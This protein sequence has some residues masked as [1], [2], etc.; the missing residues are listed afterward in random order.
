MMEVWPHFIRPW[1]L[2]AVPLPFLLLWQLTH[3]Q[4]RIGHWQRL[5]PMAFQGVLLTPGQRQRGH[6]PSW[7]LGVGWT[8]GLVALSG[9]AWQHSLP[10]AQQVAD[11]LV[12]VWEL[13][14]ELYATDASPNRLH[15]ARRKLLDLLKARQ[16]AQT[17]LL[18]F[19]GS[20]HILV[21]LSDDLATA[22]NLLSAIKPALMPEPGHRAD[23]GIAQAL[24]L[25]EQTGLGRGRLLLMGTHLDSRERNAIRQQLLK[26]P[27][28][29]LILG[30]GTPQGAPVLQEDGH[31]LQD[32]QGQ[33]VI[34]RQDQAGLMRFA[35]ERGGLYQQATLDDSDLAALGLLHPR[36]APNLQMNPRTQ[37]AWQDQGH[38]LLL[39]LLLLA[40]GAARKGWLFCFALL[41]VFPPSSYAF[42]WQDL[43]L[44][45][46]QQ[47]F[48]WLEQQQPHAAAQRFQ[49]SQ[50]QGIAYYQAENYTA[51]AAC[52]AQSDTAIAHYN[53]GNALAMNQQPDA[54]LEAY[55]RAL[56]L[57]PDLAAARQNKALL[58][59]WLA[60]RRAEQASAATQAAESKALDD[61]SIQ[62]NTQQQA[63]PANAPS[64]ALANATS[65]SPSDQASPAEAAHLAKHDA[66][67][68]EFSPERRAQAAT[69]EHQ[70][71]LEQ[72]LRRIPDDPGELLRRK[73]LYEQH[74]RQTP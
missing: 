64:D 61:A 29:L 17:A 28:P 39:P 56:S 62:G 33:I 59:D 4:R 35:Q 25:L 19:A 55:T 22:E 30:L 57:Q 45:P 54:A 74:Q 23:L 7:L 16:G 67:R 38:W 14:P 49:N 72:W 40:A 18:V 12:V 71:A 60:Q 50:W 51:A 65:T 53:R 69:T 24:S 48:Q 6:L 13:T 10:A 43:W 68:H 1:W 20:A 46:D 27:E 5:L 37:Y 26:H 31:F 21:P 36:A 70:Q 66:P 3:R 52:F 73:F 63:Q 41:L 32:D 11:P 34:A 42:D 44:T 15:Q 2:L 58:E 8:L 9:P 47:G